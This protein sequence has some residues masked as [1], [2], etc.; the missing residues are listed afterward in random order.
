MTQF[1]SAQ[2]G[3]QLVNKH[4]SGQVKHLSDSRK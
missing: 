4:V 2:E 1:L 3:K